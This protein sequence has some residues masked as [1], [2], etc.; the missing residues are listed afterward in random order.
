MKISL[1]LVFVFSAH[2]IF[3]QPSVKTTGSFHMK[4]K[5]LNSIEKSWEFAIT[6]FLGNKINKIEL[7]PD[8]SFDKTFSMEGKQ[9]VYLYINNDAITFYVQPD[10]IIEISWDAKNFE[11]SFK[12][13]GHSQWRTDELNLNLKQ[14][15][16]IRKPMMELHKKLGELR[17]APDSVKYHLINDQYNLQLKLILGATTPFTSNTEV[18]INQQYYYYAS[19]LRS[20]K[21]L[22]KF[23]LIPDMKIIN[24]GNPALAKTSIPGPLQYKGLID[25]LFYECPQY[26]V[27]LFDYVRFGNELFNM[28]KTGDYTQKTDMAPFTPGLTDYYNGLAALKIYPIRD[29]YITKVIFNSFEVY[30]YDES[31]AILNEFLPRCKTQ[32]Y[33]D[34]LVSFYQMVKKFKS[35]NPAPPFSLMNENRKLV[36]LSDF[37]GKIVYIDFWGV[38]CAPCRYEIANHVPKLHEKY[39]GKDIVFINICVDVDEKTWKK[40]LSEIKLEGINLIAEGWTNNQVCKEY[41]INGLPHYI[42]LDKQGKFVNNN[43]ARPSSI[44]SGQ[45]TEIDKLLLA[46]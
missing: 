25:K 7:L 27:F 39:A 38:G 45:N 17:N 30:T 26:R 6:G 11:K 13:G 15:F 32:V 42:L 23:T 9:E 16:A 34:T 8:G 44:M 22:Q 4:G 21:L 12:I 14:Y 41:N 3:A 43:M 33:K 36:S 1:L 28:F 31:E 35:G 19:L 46:R 10:D 37:K 29:W 2:I 18:F 5:V 24:P 20:N 40:T